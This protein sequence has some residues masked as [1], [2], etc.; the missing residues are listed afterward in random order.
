MRGLNALAREVGAEQLAELMHEDQAGG[1]R[2]HAEIAVGTPA[3]RGVVDDVAKAVGVVNRNFIVDGRL[4][5]ETR[6]QAGVEATDENA[7]RTIVAVADAVGDARGGV[8]RWRGFDATGIDD[9][10]AGAAIDVRAVRAVGLDHPAV[11][12]EESG[13]QE[14]RF[15]ISR[16]QPSA[17]IQGRAAATGCDVVVDNRAQRVHDGVARVPGREARAE[18]QAVAKDLRLQ[19]ERD[20]LHVRVIE[21]RPP[22]ARGDDAALLG[23]GPRGVRQVSVDPAP[24][25]GG[26]D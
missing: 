13:Q 12:T 21:Q 23:L 9:A 20:R 1:E 14:L 19:A 5:E 6:G 3:H 24:G 26:A 25:F 10:P 22:T 11:A 15:E 17:G 4:G 18:P 16:G 2:R 8:V 7:V